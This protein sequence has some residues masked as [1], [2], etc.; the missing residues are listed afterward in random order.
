MSSSAC[1]LRPDIFLLCQFGKPVQTFIMCLILSQVFLSLLSFC[2]LCC[3]DVPASWLPASPWQSQLSWC[4][5][6]INH[7]W[8]KTGELFTNQLW[9]VWIYY[10]CHNTTCYTSNEILCFLL[11]VREISRHGLRLHTLEHLAFSLLCWKVWKKSLMYI[12]KSLYDKASRT[13]QSPL[14]NWHRA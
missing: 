13:Q 6:D 7:H 5:L 12:S 4:R 10:R 11:W 1:T 3:C 8:I 9:A 2:W 14:Q